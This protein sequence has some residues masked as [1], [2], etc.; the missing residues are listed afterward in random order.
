MDKQNVTQK[1][2]I[3]NF[4]SDILAM[5]CLGIIIDYVAGT[6]FI[7]TLVGAGCGVVLA[8]VLKHFKEKKKASSTE[9]K[10]N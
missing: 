10:Q 4:I 6:K 8:F 9:K 5:T 7:F 3:I 1:K 2:D